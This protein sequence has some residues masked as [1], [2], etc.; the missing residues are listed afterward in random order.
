[1]QIA[2]EIEKEK[3]GKNEFVRLGTRCHVLYFSFVLWQIYYM[4]TTFG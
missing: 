1:M 4:K 2:C 3:N